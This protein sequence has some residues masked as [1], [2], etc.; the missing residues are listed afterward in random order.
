MP[1]TPDA[2]A[3]HGEAADER[4]M[5]VI[6]AANRGPAQFYARSDGKI[7]ARQASGGLAT[8]L[9]AAARR[10][11]ISWI[12]VAGSEVERRAFHDKPRRALRISGVR[13]ETRYVAIPDD[14]M[15]RLF[16]DEV[17]NRMLWFVQH[18][19]VAYE[20][21]PTF[22]PA[23]HAAWDDGYV[24]V[25][26]AVA[27]AVVAEYEAVRESGGDALI[28]VQDYHLYLVP[29]LV[30]ARLPEAKIG[31]F[32]HIP[33]PN[34]RYWEYLPHQFTMQIMQ[35][36]ASCDV[37]GLQTATDVQSFFNTVATF[38]PEAR[39]DAERGLVWLDEREIRVHAYPIGIDPE[40]VRRLAESPA[41]RRGFASLAK[42]FDH[43]D[44]RRRVMLR[45]DRLEPTK[46]IVNGLKAFELLLDELPE[47][48]RARL[49]FV[50]VLVPSREGV[51]RYRRYARQVGALVERINKKYGAPDDPRVVLVPG[52]D[53][54]RALAAMRECDVMLVNS[55]R[56]GMHLGAKEMAVVNERDS[57]LIL[58]RTAGV[59]QE[60]GADACLA[61]TPTDIQETA[62]AMRLAFNLSPAERR[63]FAGNAR[64]RVL[65]RTVTDWMNDQLDDLR[66]VDDRAPLLS[67]ITA[68]PERRMMVFPVNDRT[69]LSPPDLLP[70]LR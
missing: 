8:A 37:I 7:V 41:G 70:M 43:S 26:R 49:R 29:G 5:R 62:D 33:W 6:L 32:I 3:A 46:N 19:L 68:S 52:N 2:R 18:Y 38:L 39:Y 47:D 67:A 53:Q 25:N 60:F 16:Y 66:A 50:M 15:Y 35:S 61:V 58:S 59:Y 22:S 34:A 23:D 27:E 21:S 48:E 24:P 40:H 9:V 11:Q 31:H 12:A 14:R 28:L 20:S 63:Y 55:M 30:R 10:E 64:R 36:L 44:P 65:V 69:P 51:T 56:D 45:V 17:S 13:V 4:P 54:A 57:V 1:S 42:Y